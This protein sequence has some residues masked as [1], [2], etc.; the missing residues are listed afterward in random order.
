[1]LSFVEF[2]G[3]NSVKQKSKPPNYSRIENH[4]YSIIWSPGWLID[5]G[6]LS[7]QGPPKRTEQGGLWNLTVGSLIDVIVVGVAVT[8][9]R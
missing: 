1:M 2:K 3:E 6:I 7:Y 9:I 5:S 4:S 8:F